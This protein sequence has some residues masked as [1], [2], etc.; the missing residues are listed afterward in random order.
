MF[1]TSLLATGIVGLL[2]AGAA[3][4][5]E[6][7]ATTDLNMRAGPGPNYAVTGVIPAQAAVEVNGCIAAVNWCQVSH[8]GQTGWSYGAYLTTKIGDDLVVITDDRDLSGV[9]TIVYDAQAAPAG[10]ILG[11]PDAIGGELI[12]VV[13]GST[14]TTVIDPGD[15]VRRYV[16]GNPVEPLYLEGEVVPGARIPDAIDLRQVPDSTYSYAYVNG[17]PV[18]VEPSDRRIVYIVRQ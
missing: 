9:G 12:P 1:R 7:R 2:G 5:V 11:S 10:V 18:I 17:V 6:S 16:I 8:G 15:N 14:V 13:P 3:M 4:A